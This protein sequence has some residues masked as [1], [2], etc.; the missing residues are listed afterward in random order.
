MVNLYLYIHFKWKFK[1]FG[2]PLNFS[3]LSILFVL[4]VWL[5][6]T[7][8]QMGSVYHCFIPVMWTAVTHSYN[9][10]TWFKALLNSLT[11]LHTVDYVH[12][13][14][15]RM[16]IWLCKD[17]KNSSWNDILSSCAIFDSVNCL[18]RGCDFN[19]KL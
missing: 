18:Y 17:Y 19:T 7:L 9:V 6:L 2:V 8:V 10:K 15:M 13:W 14:R 12:Y 3:Y 5:L 4:S 11:L 1:L 16:Y